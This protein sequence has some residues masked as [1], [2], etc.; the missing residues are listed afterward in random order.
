MFRLSL[1]IFSEQFFYKAPVEAAIGG[2]LPQMFSCE[3]W[4]N[5]KNT[6]FEKRLRT[7]ATATVNECL[8]IVS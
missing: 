1:Q 4:E 6:Y 7:T 3:Y 2:V 5:F 8:L